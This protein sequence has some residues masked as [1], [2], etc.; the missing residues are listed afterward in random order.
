MIRY[1]KRQ[2]PG[3]PENQVFA[4]EAIS[5]VPLRDAAGKEAGYPRAEMSVSRTTGTSNPNFNFR[6]D[7]GRFTRDPIGERRKEAYNKITQ[8]T[9]IDLKT[10][11]SDKVANLVS[12]TA[13]NY[14][15]KLMA[16]EN[17]TNRSNRQSRRQGL[18]Y[19]KG[20]SELRKQSSELFNTTAPSTSVYSAFSH[21]KMRHTI[22]IMGAL[23]HQ[24]HGELTASG[25]LSTHSSKVVKNAM[26]KGLPIKGTEYNPNADQTNEYDFDDRSNTMSSPNTTFYN[27]TEYT[28]DEIKQA[29]MHYRQLR[30]LNSAKNTSPQFQQMQLPGI[31]Q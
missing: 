22:P 2:Y 3:T 23:A 7:T 8:E 20:I 25:S 29:K 26:S 15:N 10:V 27:G 12:N 17:D 28:P 18:E 9:G 16:D 24:E 13:D 6:Y 1:F 11:A 21:S 30:G 31:E 14:V 19:A 4:Y 5:D